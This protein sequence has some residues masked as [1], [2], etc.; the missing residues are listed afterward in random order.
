MYYDWIE[1]VKQLVPKDQLLVY[2]VKQGWEPLCKFLDIPVPN[3][4]MPRVN[5]KQQFIARR[6]KMGI[7]ICSIT[8]LWY[9]FG[10]TLLLIIVY[11]L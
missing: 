4:P 6:K 10:Y 9:G 7:V 1:Y 2:N 11:N 3:V 8:A 5:D